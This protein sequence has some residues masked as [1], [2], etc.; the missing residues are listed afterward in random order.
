MTQGKNIK[1][2][3]KNLVYFYFGN[4]YFIPITHKIW[5]CFPKKLKKYNKVCRRTNGFEM[6]LERQ[7]VRLQNF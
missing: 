1:K 7:D 5:F 4:N 6:T 3:S 2:E